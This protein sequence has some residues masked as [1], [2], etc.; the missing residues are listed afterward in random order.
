MPGTTVYPNPTR[1][2][3]PPCKRFPLAIVIAPEPINWPAPQNGI[4]CNSLQPGWAAV[5]PY[6]LVFLVNLIRRTLYGPLGRPWYR[7]IEVDGAWAFAVAATSF[8]LSV[9]ISGSL[10]SGQGNS[11]IIFLVTVFYLIP[12]DLIFSNRQV[13]A[14]IRAA[15]EWEKIPINSD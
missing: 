2:W 13:V 14:V 15:R 12:L 1:S 7:S 5:T 8:G 9:L 6:S 4:I 11:Y 10:A 3:V